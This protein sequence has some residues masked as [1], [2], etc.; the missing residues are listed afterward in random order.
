MFKVVL[1]TDIFLYLCWV[2]YDIVL[3]F[4][5]KADASVIIKLCCVS[6][7]NLTVVFHGEAALSTP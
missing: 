6:G 3:Y 7:L 4:I 5:N 1:C 2:S